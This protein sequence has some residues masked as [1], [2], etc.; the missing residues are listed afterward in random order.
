[1]AITGEQL[2]EQYGNLDQWTASKLSAASADQ[3][4]KRIGTSTI[5]S[6][7][8]IAALTTK[9]QKRKPLNL[10]SPAMAVKIISPGAALSALRPDRHLICAWCGKPFTAKDSRARFCS[11]R[12][13]QADKYQRNKTNK[14]E[15]K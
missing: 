13:R 2:C 8:F 14:L 6:A 10:E 15:K 1:M 9:K 11:N 12:C 4:R 5:F 3:N 7:S